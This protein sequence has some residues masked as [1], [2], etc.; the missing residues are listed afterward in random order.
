M[1]RFEHLMFLPEFAQSF[2]G[3][4][5]P[6]DASTHETALG[7]RQC[8]ARGTRRDIGQLLAHLR[9]FIRVAAGGRLADRLSGARGYE[10]D[11]LN[12]RE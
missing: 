12:F 5:C 3:V 8:P 4:W 9:G 2:K 11:A 10:A 6:P 7:A 1:T